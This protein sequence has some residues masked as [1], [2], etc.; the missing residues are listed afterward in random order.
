MH[1]YDLM[2]FVLRLNRAIT[3]ASIWT[4]SELW[5]V[6]LSSRMN[7]CQDSIMKWWQWLRAWGRR[8]LVIR[9]DGVCLAVWSSCVHEEKQGQWQKQS[10]TY[11]KSQDSQKWS[12]KTFVRLQIRQQSCDSYDMYRRVYDTYSSSMVYPGEETGT[13]RNLQPQRLME[14]TA[15]VKCKNTWRQIMFLWSFV[16]VRV[17]VQCSG[18]KSIGF[19]MRTYATIFSRQSQRWRFR[20]SAALKCRKIEHAWSVTWLPGC[21]WDPWGSKMAH[22]QGHNLPGG[23]QGRQ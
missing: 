18:L 9:G 13:V 7:D 12:L 14:T 20:T 3:G 6:V 5:V 21:S 22:L 8:S 15:F 16:D 17:L 10:K 11:V 4:C 1:V 23:Q 19:L 2:A